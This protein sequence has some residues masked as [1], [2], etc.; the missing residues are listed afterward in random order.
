MARKPY[1][2]DLTD[3]QWWLAEPIIPPQRPGGRHRSVD[4]R[5]VVNA[6]L[7]Q[8]RSGC[9]WRLIP[10]EFPHP[11]TVRHYY[12]RFRRD[13]TWQ[14]LHDTLRAQVRVAAGKAPTP[15]AAILDS[16]SVRVADQGGFAVSTRANA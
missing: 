2:T 11:S 4:M 9:Q 5:E 7:Y 16:Q 12:D 3:Q 10:H 8:V 13:G 1:P 15:S 14:R 6:L